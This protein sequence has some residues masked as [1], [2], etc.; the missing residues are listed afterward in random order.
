MFPELEAGMTGPARHVPAGASGGGSLA[1]VQVQDAMMQGM[2]PDEVLALPGCAAELGSASEVIWFGPRVRMGIFDGEPVRVLPH[3]T[4][5]RADYF[6]WAVAA[7]QLRLLPPG[8]LQSTAG[9][10]SQ[11]RQLPKAWQRSLQ[12]C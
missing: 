10:A 7:A 9:T 12:A 1:G 2:W 6:G 8:C 4:S 11:L 3:A 5:G